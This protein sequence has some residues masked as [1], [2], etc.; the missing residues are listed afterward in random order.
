[1]IPAINMDT[2]SNCNPT[3]T[4]YGVSMIIAGFIGYSEADIGGAIFGSFCSVI[5]TSATRN[6]GNFIVLIS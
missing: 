1:M 5:W 3:N 2:Y 6:Y 4:Y